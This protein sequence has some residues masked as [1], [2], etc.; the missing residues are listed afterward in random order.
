MGRVILLAFAGF[1]VGGLVGAFPGW[2][3]FN[4]ITFKIPVYTGGSTISQQEYPIF[5]TPLDGPA[6][7]KLK[8][9]IR[10][11]RGTGFAA[12]SGRVLERT[13]G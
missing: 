9:I 5:R 2:T 12:E 6:A 1:I 11:G 4:G 8:R 7:G 10:T 13:V 3:F